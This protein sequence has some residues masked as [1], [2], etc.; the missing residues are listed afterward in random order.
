MFCY[1]KSP[2]RLFS[3]SERAFLR[4]I[5]DSTV[6]LL[7]VSCSFVNKGVKT[8]DQRLMYG[9]KQLRDDLTISDYSICSESTL[10]LDT[11]LRGGCF[12]LSFSILLILLTAFLF[13]CCTCGMSLIAFP[14]LLPFLFILPCC[15]L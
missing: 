1:T 9:G 14:I 3:T 4:L 10:H 2:A 13:S 7:L 12:V 11:R 15:C 6:F 5:P 8:A